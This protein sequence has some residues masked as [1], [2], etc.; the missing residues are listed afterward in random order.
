MPSHKQLSTHWRLQNM[1]NLKI[2]F[3]TIFWDSVFWLYTLVNSKSEF[4]NNMYLSICRVTYN[5]LTDGL[6][7]L[8]IRWTFEYKGVPIISKWI[9]FQ[10]G[11]MIAVM[12]PIFAVVLNLPNGTKI[13]HSII[14]WTKSGEYLG[15]A[16]LLRLFMMGLINIKMT[17]YR[18][19]VKGL[20]CIFG[21][22]QEFPDMFP[23]FWEMQTSEKNWGWGRGLPPQKLISFDPFTNCIMVILVKGLFPDFSIIFPCHQSRNP[24]KKL[25]TLNPKF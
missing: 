17:N 22:S 18:K 4:S 24:C 2:D 19:R 12:N 8:Y 7:T 14:Y 23:G 1:W 13:W 6:P 16:Y 5:G 10:I 20:A 21:L 3:G 9:V 15:I 25:R 11:L